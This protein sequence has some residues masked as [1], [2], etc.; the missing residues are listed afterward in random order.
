[1]SDFHD[2]NRKTHADIFQTSLLPSQSQVKTQESNY[3]E[4]HRTLEGA[5]GC[6]MK[7]PVAE[8]NKQ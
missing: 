5:L 2:A 6:G 8:K 1:M 4:R 3:L 7:G